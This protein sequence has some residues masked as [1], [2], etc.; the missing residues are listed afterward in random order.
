MAASGCPFLRLK[1]FAEDRCPFLKNLKGVAI[2]AVNKSVKCPV[3][4]DDDSF[5]E[6]YEMFHGEQGVV[7]RDPRAIAQGVVSFFEEET[8]GLGG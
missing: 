1:A 4:S 8:I 7:P 6:A 2:G 5:V 3:L